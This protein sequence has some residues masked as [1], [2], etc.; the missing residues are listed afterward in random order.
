[1]T[2]A[3]A[4]LRVQP[5]RPTVALAFF[6]GA[7]GAG[8]A[9]YNVIELTTLQQGH[10]PVVRG[11][12]SAGVAV[13]GGK[14]LGNE[15][16]SGRRGLL[17]PRS[18]G[19]QQVAGLP[20]TDDTIVFDINDTGA[21]VG[22]SNQASNVRAFKGNGG[23]VQELP[24][25]AGDNS[26]TAYSIN[27]L[28]QAVG[29]SSGPSGQRA[30]SW[31]A[32]GVARLLA[33]PAGVSLSRASGINVRGD[34]VGVVN[35]A[36]GRRPVIWPIGAQVATELMLLPGHVTG[37]AMAI[38]N[39]GDAVGYSANAA[40]L[41]RATLWPANAGPVDLGTLPGGTYSR[42][43]ES[44][45]AGLVVGAA[46]SGHESRAFVWTQASGMQD[47]NTLITPS[48]FL[49]TQAVGINN[50]G[51]ILATGHDAVAHGQPGHA[52]VEA[53]DLPVRVFLLVRT[54]GP[55]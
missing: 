27:N 19:A 38:N 28:G 40:A 35:T 8:A 34:I 12:N 16:R 42:A 36:A 26:S 21:F 3:R 45:D 24:A 33:V 20:G 6:L 25:L 43:L 23:A 5:W 31:D 51:D 30:V 53:H 22:S 55:Q 14:V 1:M 32:N 44:N 54:G 9:T 4:L 7:T 29:F 37:E 48:N 46:G 11:V 47:L 18:G 15:A 13:G 2:R 49:L 50:V 52:H 17:I 39:R 10:V 41:P